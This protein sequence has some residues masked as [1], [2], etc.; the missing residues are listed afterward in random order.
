MIVFSIIISV[1][2]K[3]LF[4]GNRETEVKNSEMKLKN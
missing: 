1:P 3:H 2:R 4:K